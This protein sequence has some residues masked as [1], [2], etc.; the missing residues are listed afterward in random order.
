[1]YA[2]VQTGGKQYPVSPGERVRVE[3]LQ[4]E[5]GGEV[6]LDQV[7]LVGDDDDVTVGTPTVAGATVSGT[8]VS[9]GR[10]PKL[11]VYKLRKRKDSRR[12]Q[13]HRQDFTEIEV[14]E[15]KHSA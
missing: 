7:L 15:I 10:G 8:I 2:I 12:K 9:H 11:I 6:E 1:M 3:K 5:V 4:G 14:T 13:G